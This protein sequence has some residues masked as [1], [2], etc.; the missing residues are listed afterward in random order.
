MN[1]I[2]QVI[3]ES[4]FRHNFVAKQIGVTPNHISMWISN[5]RI[6]NK[7]RIRALCKVLKCKVVDLYPEG[8]PKK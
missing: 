1:N 3:Q 4:G 7:P 5:E 8:I 6:P 2:K